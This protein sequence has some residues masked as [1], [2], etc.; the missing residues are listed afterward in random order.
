MA[1]REAIAEHF[2]A[3]VDVVA[4]ELPT[5]YAYVL[6]KLTYDVRGGACRFSSAE[7]LLHDHRDERLQPRIRPD[8]DFWDTK[9]ATDVVV[10]GVAIGGPAVTK[11]IVSVKVGDSAKRIAVY[12]RR[13]IKWGS[14]G[15]CRVEEPEPFDQMAMTYANAYGGIDWRVPPEDLSS[16][17]LP[18]LL[19]VDHP[20][21]YP[22][23]PFGKGYLVQ[24][25]DVPGMEMPNLEDPADLLTAER[26]IVGDPRLWYRQPLPW[27]LDWVH[28]AMFPRK[29]LLLPGADAWYP[30]PDDEALPEVERG[31]L[32]SGARA[33]M[34]DRPMVDGPHPLFRQG[35]S[36]GMVFGELA[37]GTPFEIGGMNRG[38]ELLSYKLPAPPDVQM[39]VDGDWQSVRPSLHHVVCRP[40]EFKV[41]L[42]YGARRE[43]PRRFIKGVHKHIPVAAQINGQ[44]PFEYETPP[45]YRDQICA[46]MREQHST[47]EEK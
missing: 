46:A 39:A 16:P 28:P 42:V 17:L 5:G 25:G 9:S 18:Q 24:T 45:T 36:S 8:T 13:W 1:N 3:V 7:P 15:R 30:G 37:Q 47:K 29:L 14:G 34:T 41:N 20:G 33:A 19:K 27:C 21:L 4:P 23:N 38:P 12:G 22:R 43:L 35:G 32:P 31:F 26:L 2:D 11:A 40:G 6:I 10:Q 44:G